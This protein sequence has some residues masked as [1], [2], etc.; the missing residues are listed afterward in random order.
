MKT[1]TIEVSDTAAEKIERM[2]LNERNAIAETI[3]ALV[4][5]RRSLAEIMQEASE[6]ARK[7]GLTPEILEELLRDE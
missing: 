6:Q 7:N 3:T 5:N 2:S 4:V 1:I